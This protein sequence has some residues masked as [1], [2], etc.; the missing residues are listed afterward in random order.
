MV[1]VQI[2]AILVGALFGGMISFIWAYTKTQKKGHLVGLI[3]C[4][5]ALLGLVF[6]ISQ[7]VLPSLQNNG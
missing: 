2:L 7:Y 4:V 5:V 6:Y 1:S 3:I